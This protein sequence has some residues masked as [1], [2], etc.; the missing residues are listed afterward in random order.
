MEEE[1]GRESEG[2]RSF[3]LFSSLPSPPFL[4]SQKVESPVVLGSGSQ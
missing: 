1:G 3:S 4:L 2:R